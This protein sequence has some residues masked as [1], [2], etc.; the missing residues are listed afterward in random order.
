MHS[1]SESHM[2]ASV[3]GVFRTC[4][5]PWSQSRTL[6]LHHHKAAHALAHCRTEAM[7]VHIQRCVNGDYQSVQPNACRSR[8][9]PR[10]SSL[11]RE[12]WVQ[13]QAGKLLPCSHYHMVFT[14]PHELLG[15]FGAERKV[16]VSVLFRSVRETLMTLLGDKRHLG[17]E[18]GLLM[19]LHTWGRNLSRH[20]HIH[21]LVTDG[22]LSPNGQWRAPK[23]RYL[24][25]VQVVKRLY[26]NKFL[27]LLHDAINR[28]QLTSVTADR[29]PD[30]H[31]LLGRLRTKDWHVRL[32]ERYDHGHGVM[33]YLARYVKD[34]PIT[35]TRIVSL[36]DQHVTFRY[37][38]HR[39]GQRK[40][41]TLKGIDFMAR[42]LWHLPERYQH[43]VRAAGLYGNRGQHK[44]NQC[45]DSMG[46]GPEAVP[47]QLS[48]QAY[49]KQLG[50]R[51]NTAC[52]RCGGALE[53][54]PQS[55]Q[56]QI[57]SIGNVSLTVFVQ[58][59]VETDIATG[60]LPP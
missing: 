3:R 12:R 15:L 55:R 46:A 28:G 32:K 34:G 10:C 33:K 53:S 1:I 9:C 22:G 30:L 26:R 59:T 58:Q 21:V 20:P 52:P 40:R 42:L 39:D 31:R 54:R 7:G 49:L 17:V 14:L 48:W 47:A 41:M 8:S 5:K 45:R 25:P 18:P 43:L 56:N 6:P 4:F 16:L 13:S 36:R 29:R 2:E 19:A 37:R 50:Y 44:R 23:G 35:D 24:L 27:A 38:D 57:S 51:A 11:A 60:P